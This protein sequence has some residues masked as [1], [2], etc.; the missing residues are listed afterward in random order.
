MLH[1][2]RECSTA[3]AIWA[4]ML[5]TELRGEFY[6]EVVCSKKLVG[7]EFAFVELVIVFR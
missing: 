2:L 5:T 1:V 6:S 4:Q 3:R 7:E